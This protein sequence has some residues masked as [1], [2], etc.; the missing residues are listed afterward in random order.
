MKAGPLSDFNEV[1]NQKQ[2][3]MSFGSVWVISADFSGGGE[4]LNPS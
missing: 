2:G 4:S 1:G 3:I